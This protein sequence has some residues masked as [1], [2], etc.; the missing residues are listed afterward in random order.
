MGFLFAGDM[1][2]PKS[3]IVSPA[4]PLTI[5]NVVA[6]FQL[7]LIPIHLDLEYVT[8]HVEGRCDP[9]IFPAVVG[10]VKET[11]TR[12]NICS[13]GKVIL[14]GAANPR[15]AQLTA[16]LLCRHL[17]SLY[18]QFKLSVY[19]LYFPNSPIIANTF[20]IQYSDERND[21]LSHSFSFS[22]GCATV[23]V[24]CCS[25]GHAVDMNKL[26]QYMT[27]IS[28]HSKYKKD[29]FRQNPLFNSITIVKTK[30]DSL[31]K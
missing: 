20:N 14:T 23:V 19:N 30:R 2:Q 11:N 17:S 12:F 6:L 24:A 1:Q 22:M 21:S 7:S 10:T 4:S 26:Y 5:K 13:S 29:L 25:L 15:I 31:S 18:P 28:H 3:K 9:S 16:Y 8:Y 27:E